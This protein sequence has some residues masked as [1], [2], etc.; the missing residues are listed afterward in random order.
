MTSVTI[1]MFKRNLYYSD[2]T[3]V[4]PFW[5]FIA[6]V[7]LLIVPGFPLV[8]KHPVPLAILLVSFVITFIL[9]AFY[10]AYVD[11]ITDRYLQKHDFKLWKRTKKSSHRERRQAAKEIE[12]LSRQIPY[13]IKNKKRVDKVI[14]I[15][16][17]IW[18]LIFLGIFLFI[19]FTA[20]LIELFRD[21]PY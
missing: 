10:F 14:F 3:K 18:T 19:V 4:P 2:G 6:P 8:T 5:I 12:S 1:T 9:I 16:F 20:S 21:K 17:V 11:F 13:L 7:I 15:L